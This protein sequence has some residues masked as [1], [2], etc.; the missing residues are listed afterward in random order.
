MSN[1]TINY[2]T[3]A[4]N[5]GLML[6]TTVTIGY[7]TPWRQVHQLLIDAATETGMIEKEP[8]PFVW[9]TSLDDFYVTYRLNAFTR[10]PGKQFVLYS[11]LHAN[12]QDHFNKAGVEIMSPHYT[13]LR[14]G[15]MT[16]IPPDYLPK[17]YTQPVFQTQERKHK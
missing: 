8:A 13:S 15:N 17:D 1:H 7:D 4:Q 6:H 12:I 3:E 9:Q 16:S 10:E 2:S 11:A 14:D 5:E